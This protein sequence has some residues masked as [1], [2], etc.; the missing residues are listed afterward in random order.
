[1][2]NH[3]ER[4]A[5]APDAKSLFAGGA[6]GAVRE[7]DVPGQRFARHWRHNESWVGTLAV[8]PDG[9]Y[10]AAG[11]CGQLTLGNGRCQGGGLNVWSLAATPP[12][13]LTLDGRAPGSQGL[14][15]SPDG[16]SLVTADCARLEPDK[17]EFALC[18]QGE[19]RRWR[20]PGGALESFPVAASTS[21]IVA[22]A[23]SP[24]GKTLF[25]GE[26]EGPVHPLD[27]STLQPVGA[28]FQAE[29]VALSGLLVSPQLGGLLVADSFD[30]P[31]QVWRLNAPS[32]PAASLAARQGSTFNTSLA[33]SPGGRVLAVAVGAEVQLWDL[34]LWHPA[35][36]VV[37]LDAASRPE[38][39]LPAAPAA[40]VALV[41]SEGK[42]W[43]LDL[44]SGRPEGDVLF[45]G[46]EALL[47]VRLS[48]DGTRAATLDCVQ[49]SSAK[50]PSC[51]Q[52]EVRFWD[53]AAWQ[54]L[55]SPARV[56][57]W[58]LHAVFSPDSTRLAVDGPGDTVLVLDAA[59][60]AQVQAISTGIDLG[61]R[62]LSF[63]SDS[64]ALAVSGCLPEEAKPLCLSHDVVRVF[65]VATG[66][67]VGTT[68]GPFDAQV[69]AL[70]MGSAGRDNL[71]ALAL[72]SLSK[73]QWGLWDW[74]TGTQV[75]EPLVGWVKALAFS[76]DGRL[77][78]AAG[79]QDTSAARNAI[80]LWDLEQ[81]QVLGAP[82]LCDAGEVRPFL[83]SPDGARL[84]S[85]TSAELIVWSLDPAGWQQRA[86]HVAHR[87]LSADEWKTYVGDSAYHATCPDLP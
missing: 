15:F 38:V 62:E 18:L 53:A 33:L 65:D 20:L 26:G 35:E 55:G 47:S 84:V 16:Q 2:S 64:A 22:L 66:S 39:A 37:R 30:R 52:T 7:W 1:M 46:D 10:L 75:G 87:N 19:V 27:S 74:Q 69:T 56:S 50:V 71:V 4:C 82:L 44:S 85:S 12:L 11:N 32:S 49:R 48:P 70:A 29:G 81:G 57:A 31:A 8:S 25:A 73:K 77:L 34:V 86:C 54:P 59:T 58:V 14:A 3:C 41:H 63:A 23:F 72:W 6:G 42:L 36:Q 68:I 13:T 40:P 80:T 24:D 79:P 60:G 78:A 51:L 21:A 61:F 9:R 67:Q 28:P 83:F 76:P 17:P 45:E 5:Y 43:R